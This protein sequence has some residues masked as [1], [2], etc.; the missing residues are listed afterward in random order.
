[1]KF[2]LV[3]EVLPPS[4]SGQAVLIRRLL[5]GIEPTNYCLLTSDQGRYR[6]EHTGRLPGVHHRL[7]RLPGAYWS[8][9]NKWL[10]GVSA[11]INALVG[12]VL[13][14]RQIRRVVGRE[15]C[16]S[17]VAFT[18]DFHDLPASYLASRSLR[19]PLYVYMCD[20][21]AYR[22]PYE[23]ARRRLS[24]YLEPLVLRRAVGVICGNETLADA[25]RVRY[26][27]QPTVIHHPADL[28]LYRDGAR[29]QSV[30]ATRELR[31]VYTGTVYDAQLDAVQDLLEALD[32][33]GRGATLHVFGGQPEEELRA[34]GLRGRLVVH[35]HEAS[36]AI[37]AAQQA[38]DILFLPL[39]FR[40]LYPEVVRTSAP[41]KLGEYLAAGGPILVHAPAG[42]FVSEY[43]RRHDCARVVDQADV[44]RLAEAIEELASDESLRARLIRNARERA[45]RDFSTD[46]ARERFSELLGLAPTDGGPR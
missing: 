1:M 13:R 43:C 8:R 46:V 44:G 25:L 42:S 4:W 16:R 11:L 37:A 17:I 20:Y 31:I 34:R 10:F 36:D 35:P 29:P 22:E 24:P 26:G 19:L 45:R 12:I 7:P 6:G 30:P 5:D 38:A 9:S 21:Y 14:A 3:S 23:P 39:A 18:G 41:M 28:S 15:K 27:V 40:S 2:A 33:L 32:R